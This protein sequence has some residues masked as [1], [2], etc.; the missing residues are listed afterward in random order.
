MANDLRIL[1]KTIINPEQSKKDIQNQLDKIKDVKLN[2]GIDTNA[3][4][5]LNKQLQSVQK[6]LNGSSLKGIKIINEDEFKRLKSSGKDIKDTINDIKAHYKGLGQVKF[7]ENIDEATG[8]LKTFTVQLEKTRGVVE[9]FTYKPLN[10]ATN[11]D[12]FETKFMLSTRNIADNKIKTEK[13]ISDMW[14]KNLK[15]KETKEQ[16]SIQKSIQRQS[17]SYQKLTADYEQWWL[18]ALHNKEQAELK[19]IDKA[20]SQALS[21]NK[22]LNEQIQNQT[23]TNTYKQDNLLNSARSLM[24][25]YHGNVDTTAYN[26]LVASIKAINPASKTAEED[27]KKIQLQLGKLKVEAMETSRTLS[28]QL[29]HNLEKMLQWT[30]VSTAIFGA[31]NAFRFLSTTVIDIDKNLTELSKVLSNQTDFKQL[32]EDVSNTANTY[33]RSLTETQEALTEFGKAGYEASEAMK[34]TDATLLGANVTGLKT[35]QMADYLT[36]ALTQFGMSAEQAVDVVNKINEVDNN[37]AVT[38]IGLAQSLSRAG[39]SAHQFGSSMDDLIAMTTLVSQATHESGTVIGNMFKTTFA[40]L[41]MDKTQSALQSIGVAV[42]D[43]NGDMRSATDIYADVAKQWDNMTR[44]QRTNIAENLA[45]K[46]HINRMMAMLDGWTD[47]EKG[48]DAIVRTSQNS[49]GSAL[50]ENKKHMESLDAKMNQMG[51]SAQ[52][53]AYTIGE[54]GLK[55][56]LKSSFEATTTF[57]KGLT[58][59]V[60]SLSNT[61]STMLVL[62]GTSVLFRNKMIEAAMSLQALFVKNPWMLV[63]TGVA[64][65]IG[66]IIYQVGKYK[67]ENE[68]FEKTNA[69]TAE[70][71]TNQREQIDQLLNKYEELSK[72]KENNALTPEKEQ[73]YYNVQKQ[74]NL[75]LPQ[76]TDHID[77]NGNAIIKRGTALEEEKQRLDELT[78]K[79][80]DYQKANGTQNL[81]DNDQKLE[82]KLD[83]INTLKTQIANGGEYNSDGFFMQFSDGEIAKLRVQLINLES[84]FA[85]LN[86]SGQEAITKI[87][88]GFAK[89]D[90]DSANS[91]HNIIGNLDLTGQNSSKIAID[92]GEAV[93]SL[94]SAK[95]G[96]DPKEIAFATANLRELLTTYGVAPEKVQ[97]FID[98]M[99]GVKKSTDE[100]AKSTFDLNAIQMEVSTGVENFEKANKELAQTYDKLAEGQK[101]SGKEIFDLISKYPELNSAVETHNGILSLNKDAVEAVMLAKENEFKIDLETKQQELINQ[102]NAL[103]S[104][105]SMYAAEIDAIES[106]A[107]AK[108]IAAQTTVK[109]V[110]GLKEAG[111]DVDFTTSQAISQGLESQFVEIGKIRE[112]KHLI[113]SL[114]GA[115]LGASLGQSGGKPKKEPKGKQDTYAD[116][117]FEAL[118]TYKEQVEDLKNSI[119]S[120]D[121][122]VKS[123]QTAIEVAD[124]ADDKKKKIGLENQLNQALEDRKTKYHEIADQMRDIRDN[125]LLSQFDSLFPDFRQG[126]NMEDIG[127]AEFADYQNKLNEMLNDAENKAGHSDSV[128][129][130]ERVNQ[131]K[132]MIEQ[133]KYLSDTVIQTDKDIS[134]LGVKYM[135]DV[136]KIAET[137]KKIHEDQVAIINEGLDKQKIHIDDLDKDIELSKAR[138]ALYAEGSKEFNAQLVVQSQLLDQKIQLEE[139]YQKT[140]Q[141]TLDTQK[142]LT[143]EERKSLE[144]KQHESVMRQLADRREKQQEQ[145]TLRSQIADKLST[146]KQ[147]SMDY[148]KQQHDKQEKNLEDNLKAV[149]KSYDDQID[150][151]EKKLKLLDDEYEK[152]DRI[153]KLN[154]VND[155]LN[156]ALNDKRYSYI[157]EDGKEILTYNKEKVDEL[158][159]QRDDMLAQYKRDDIKKAIQDDIDTLKKQKDDRVEILHKQLDEVKLKNQQDEEETSRH[160][161]RLIDGARNGTLSQSQLMDSWFSSQVSKM[162]NFRGE[163]TNLVSQIKAAYEA[164]NQIQ[165]KPVV[166][167]PPIYSLPGVPTQW[168]TPSPN[169]SGGSNS[170]TDSWSYSPSSGYS[171]GS[172]SW[173]TTDTDS[174]WNSDAD[175]NGTSWGSDDLTPPSFDTGGF[176]GSGFSDGK[177]AILHQ[178]ELVLNQMDTNN[179]LKAVNLVRN[180]PKMMI[181]NLSSLI[182][183]QPTQVDQSKTYQFNNV[184]IKSDDPLNF[185]DQ[186]NWLIRSQ[187]T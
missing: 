1:I 183:K 132:S 2:I 156:K 98:V 114:K 73:E 34:L 154:E 10:I 97:G 130:K 87:V 20:H 104:K 176:T 64:T 86:N 27:L 99:N 158:T 187:T 112:Q 15:N 45:G 57:I 26:Q 78:D 175:G 102:E 142:D 159:K 74:L 72:A 48:F 174:G 8:R 126:R 157:T 6:M 117:V 101:L 107:Q 92:I 79:W 93:K 29:A 76:L 44:A 113:E 91:L 3:L 164:L 137:T 58:V 143:T 180:L 150:K 169:Y 75:L 110:Q 135:D 90:K 63:A 111:F 60:D 125:K 71:W 59:T 23:S 100:A 123:L 144:N 46:Y 82:A 61:N 160:W 136:S 145:A 162:G 129:D 170:G 14:E 128:A 178:K 25:Q 16:Q 185:L 155:N 138:Q 167:P 28:S 70:T 36:G 83:E 21:A 184:T 182:N 41:N 19:V 152:E 148:L 103:T 122:A 65:A 32:M 39:E 84:E 17:E 30:A 47:K 179:I 80:H 153:K 115:N 5:N 151:L 146:L 24:V 141:N 13:Q 33:G 31:A 95:T 55:T 18:K 52:E 9:K 120:A 69:K 171:D 168:Y 42:H 88:D 77:A 50:E 118:P 166:I 149:E 96:G 133:F 35:A 140:I 62:I 165:L 67:Q 37:F 68:E 161:E 43:L 53:L 127:K 163:V 66:T 49:F 172:D 11:G 177:L 121:D 131:I 134:D 116:K 173:S 56:A 119:Q 105:L 38:S 89:L 124:K 106:V 109:S 54:A 139:E 22:R 7:T 181:P 4:S 108:Q 94:Q 186:I 12:D 40:R 85:N 81:A 51:A 147:D